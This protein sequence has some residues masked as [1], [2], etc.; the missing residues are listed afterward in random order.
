MEPGVGKKLAST[1]LVLLEETHFRAG[2]NTQAR[3]CIN[4]A[5][6]RSKLQPKVL[7]LASI[8]L[9]HQLHA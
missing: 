6:C 5:T 1:R 4:F 2:M 7:F 8:I 9:K 3:N